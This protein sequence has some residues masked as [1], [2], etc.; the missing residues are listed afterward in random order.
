M[1]NSASLAQRVA[2]ANASIK[3]AMSSSVIWRGVWLSA[4]NGMG[5]GAMISQARLSGSE[6]PPSHATSQLAFRPAWASWMAIFASEWLWTKSTTRFQ[7]STCSGLYMPA[8]PFE[9]RPSGE[10]SVISVMTRP[11]PPIARLPRCTTCQ[12]FTVP[13]TAEYWHIG[14]MTRRFLT[15]IPRSVKGVNM[16]VS[17]IS[18][19]SLSG[20]MG[21][22]V[23]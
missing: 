9:I 22:E 16:G 5:D 18:V 19:F 11:V 6:P 8:Q 12:S 23:R 4:E 2:C 17:D 10:T 3:R 13:S 15:V 20:S 21:A 1:S 7:A 14:D